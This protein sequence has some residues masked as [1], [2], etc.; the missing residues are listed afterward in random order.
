MAVNKIKSLWSSG[1]LVFKSTTSSAVP[2]LQVG[3]TTYGLQAKFHQRPATAGSVVEVRSRPSS[4]GAAAHAA[5]DATLD[6]RATGDTV[7]AGYS[8]ALQGVCRMDAG[9]TITGGSLTGV[10]GQVALN[11]TAVANGADVFMNALYGLIEDGGT[12]TAVNHLAIAWL[13][14]HLTK[15][16]SS[17]RYSGVYITNNGSTNFDQIFY[18][19]AGAS[20]LFTIEDPTKSFVSDEASGDYTFSGYRKIKVGFG[21]GGTDVGYLIVD[22]A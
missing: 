14:T 18:I 3:Q 7:T 13:D 20:K 1:N 11:A 6:W 21:A 19:Y 16:V 5:V 22:M 17:G 8:R 12:Y 10:Y 2:V 4:A 15:T 9:N